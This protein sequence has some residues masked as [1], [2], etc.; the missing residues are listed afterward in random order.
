MI[1]KN[2]FLNIWRTG[3]LH[4]RRAFLMLRW[5]PAPHY[6]LYGILLRA[7]SVA[8]L[9]MLPRALMGLQ[10]LSAPGYPFITRSNYYWHALWLYPV[11]EIGCWLLFS[12]LIHLMLRLVGKQSSYDAILNISG[13]STIIVEPALR[14]W[15]WLAFA[16]G[17]NGN[18]VFLGVSHILLAWSWGTYLAAVAYQEI[19]GVPPRWSVPLSLLVNL[20]FIPLA[21]VFLRP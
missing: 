7:A 8:L 1:S 2:T 12:G 17:W 11:F 16:L 21:A 9:W 13:M 4:P 19:L 5:A 20:L 6:G 18:L 10:P 14:L 15:D 3:Y